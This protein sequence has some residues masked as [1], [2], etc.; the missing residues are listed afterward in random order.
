[1]DVEMVT[2]EEAGF[3]KVTGKIP[4]GAVTLHI[5]VWEG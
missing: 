2:C 1:M 4:V 3:M 5:R